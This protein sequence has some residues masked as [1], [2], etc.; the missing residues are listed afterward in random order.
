MTYI[1]LQKAREITGLCGNT[2]RKYADSGKI[3]YYRLPNGD[4]RF[5][6]SAFVRQS[7]H[8]IGYTRVSTHN[9]LDDLQCQSTIIHTHYPGAEIIQDI[10]SGISFKRKGLQTLL[11]RAL[12]GQSLTVVVTHRDRLT[13]FG[14]DLLQG[15]VERSGGTVV[16]LHQIST[17]PVEELTRDLAAISKS[18]GYRRAKV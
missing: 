11:E 15:L 5:D 12:Q 10:G 3:P 7:R 2:L 13:R 9:Q 17:S 18:F 4:R 1:S 16:D 8:V 6:V 14:F